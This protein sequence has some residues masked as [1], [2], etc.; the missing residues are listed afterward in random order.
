MSR[1][2]KQNAKSF[3]KS[4]L[5]ICPGLTE[6]GYLSSMKVDRYKGLAIEL[7]PKL[8]KADK[9]NEVFRFLREEYSDPSTARICIYVNDMD[10]I[11][12]QRKTSEYLADKR[13]TQKVSR[14]ELKV[15]ETMPCIEYWFILHDHYTDKY[16]PSYDSLKQDMKKIADNY[17]KNE[18]WAGKI[19]S[20]LK[21][22]LTRAI[23]NAEKTMSKKDSCEGDC[24]Y[25]N[26]HELVQLLDE[27]H[28][29]NVHRK[30]P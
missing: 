11:L 26:M 28:R 2:R 4:I 13:R 10:T 6:K 9:F 21:N 27:I 20:V 17:E 29:Q 7:E 25:T 15:I 3:K 18:H 8:G 16:Y 14:D 30:Q 5:I 12:S 23:Q 1:S 24:S 19:Y 22:N